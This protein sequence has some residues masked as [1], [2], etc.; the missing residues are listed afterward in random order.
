MTTFIARDG[1]EVDERGMSVDLESYIK[2]QSQ[3]ERAKQRSAEKRY[4]EKHPDKI[5]A[6]NKKFRSENPEYGSVWN[7]NNRDKCAQYEQR[8]SAANPNKLR[9]KNRQWRA[10]N[11][12]RAKE[13]RRNW[14]RNNPEKARD[15]DLRGTYGISLQQWN[16]M[17]EAQG[18]CCAVCERSDPGKQGWH[19]DHDHETGQVRGILCYKCNPG[20]GMFGDDVGRLQRAIDYLSK[21]KCDEVD[22]GVVW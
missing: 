3:R 21:F 4:R 12:E 10:K 7:K 6:K 1:V 8:Y 14:Y 22:H 13:L 2:V 9:E 5:K 17:F 11:P 20:L 18:R 16:E 15:M 19:T